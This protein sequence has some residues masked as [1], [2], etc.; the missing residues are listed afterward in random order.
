MLLLQYVLSPTFP[1]GER[2][3]RKK[4]KRRRRKKKKE[5]ERREEEKKK[6]RRKKKKEEEKNRRKKKKR[7][8]EFLLSQRVFPKS[9]NFMV[10][11]RIKKKK[12]ILELTDNLFSLTVVAVE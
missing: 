10:N 11:K 2:R 8:K 1:V 5:E 4:K 3:R 9:I 7:R 6:K 12:I